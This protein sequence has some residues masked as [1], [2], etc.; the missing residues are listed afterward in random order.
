VIEL[1]NGDRLLYASPRLQSETIPDPDGGKPWTS[2]YVTYST[3]R[4][5]GWIRERA[6]GGLFVENMGQAIAN[7]VLRAAMQRVHLDTLSVPAISQYLATLPVGARTGICLHVH[8]EVALDVP[9]GSYSQERFRAILT[10]RPAWA[11]DLP[12]AVDLWTN[13]RYGKR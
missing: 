7:R 1:P 2:T 3:V 10:Q 6:W 9:K 11:P 4:G 12:I 13:P 5:R 8:D